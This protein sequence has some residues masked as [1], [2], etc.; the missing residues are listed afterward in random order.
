MKVPS[1]GPRRSPPRRASRGA[2]RAACGAVL[3]LGVGCAR[4]RYGAVAERIRQGAVP[5][6]IVESVPCV[7]QA[8]YQCGPA[9]L[10]MVLGAWGETPDAA[11][12]ADAVFRDERRATLTGAM[13]AYPD[14][15]RY[16]VLAGPGDVREI[17]RKVAAGMA[18]IALLQPGRPLVR[19][20]HY[21]VVH[22]TDEQAR[23]FLLRSGTRCE[24]VMAWDLF[25]Y[26][27]APAGRWR[28]VV[29][30]PDR[31]SWRLAPE[32]RLSRGLHFERQGEID[33]AEADYVAGLAEAP[34]LAQLYINL[35]N[36]WM[37]GQRWDAA[38]SLLENGLTATV[39]DRRLVN[40]LAWVRGEQGRFSEA[41]GLAREAVG[42]D[43]ETARVEYLD[44]LGWVLFR[45]GAR[46]EACQWLGLARR[47]AEEIGAGAAVRDWLAE[48]WTAACAPESIADP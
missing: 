7:R 10:A 18:V 40:S 46:A 4:T 30:P 48:H 33:L 23:L 44:T 21:Y 9:A 29:C 15:A 26:R 41:E 37:A 24:E 22:G 19:A 34:G 11:A 36:L 12:I 39:R 3:A 32:E 5:G 1:Q 2:I 35:S 47:R 28:M 27:W 38:A 25:D 17:S 45:A 8:R 13:A 43:P 14:P 16:W 31:A 6:G 20:G 42:P